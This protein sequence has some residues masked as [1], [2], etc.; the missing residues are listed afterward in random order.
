MATRNP[1]WPS[2][3]VLMV[4]CDLAKKWDKLPSPQLVNAGFLVPINSITTLCSY[5]S[6]MFPLNQKPE[7]I[8]DVPPKM[9]TFFSH[10][11]RAIQPIQPMDPSFS[12]GNFPNME[13]HIL[14]APNHWLCKEKKQDQHSCLVSEHFHRNFL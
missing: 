1:G 2:T 9:S 7:E 8:T 12:P 5:F 6:I 3:W 10:Y 14:K 13:G 11:I 4:R